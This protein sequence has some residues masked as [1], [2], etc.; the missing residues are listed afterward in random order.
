MYDFAN[1]LLQILVK[2]IL[3]RQRP[4]AYQRTLLSRRATQTVPGGRWEGAGRIAEMM[5]ILPEAMLKLL[6]SRSESNAGI[7]H[8][9]G[10]QVNPNVSVVK[11][12]SRPKKK[13]SQQR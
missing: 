6:Q 5:S 10:F 2:I 11:L 12:V 1:A 8:L 3:L 9:L 4:G 13:D 7:R